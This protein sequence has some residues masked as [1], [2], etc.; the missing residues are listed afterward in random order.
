MTLHHKLKEYTKQRNSMKKISENY[1]M[2]SLNRSLT[3][4]SLNLT[5]SLLDPHE[6][7]N[8]SVFCH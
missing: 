1:L 5:N 4:S 3:Q 7:E 8:K 6:P 2:F